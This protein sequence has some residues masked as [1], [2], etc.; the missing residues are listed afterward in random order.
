MHT[1]YRLARPPL[2]AR[3]STASASMQLSVIG[4]RYDH[5]SRLGGASAALMVGRMGTLEHNKATDSVGGWM[6]GWATRW[7]GTITTAIDAAA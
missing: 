7:V 4:Y 2:P 1:G 6:N 5:E 3:A